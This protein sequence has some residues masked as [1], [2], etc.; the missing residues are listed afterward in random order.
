MARP[1]HLLAA[2][3][4][5]ALQLRG[6]ERKTVGWARYIVM[7]K[8]KGER[9]Q[10]MGEEKQWLLVATCRNSRPWKTS[11]SPLRPAAAPPCLPHGPRVSVHT[12]DAPTHAP[13]PWKVNLFPRT[14]PEWGL[15]LSQVPWTRTQKGLEAGAQRGHP[16]DHQAPG[17]LAYHHLRRAGVGRDLSSSPELGTAL[18]M[19][20]SRGPRGTDTQS[21]VRVE[22]ALAEE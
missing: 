19:S 2:V 1:R 16:P 14:G 10:L 5:F 15:R 22:G 13:R 11:L 3:M 7:T 4:T 17:V 9:S 20:P 21:C 18:A 6:R 12:A 8:D